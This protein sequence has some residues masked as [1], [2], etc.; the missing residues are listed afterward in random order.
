MDGGS[1][2]DGDCCGDENGLFELACAAAF[3]VDGLPSGVV[4][5][6]CPAIV[7]PG[8]DGSARW[9]A[10]G[11]ASAAGGCG[12][13]STPTCIPAVAAGGFCGVTGVLII[14]ARSRSLVACDASCTDVSSSEAAAI[15]CCDRST[16]GVVIRMPERHRQT[17][18]SGQHARSM[19]AQMSERTAGQRYTD[20][21]LDCDRRAQPACERRQ[22]RRRHSGGERAGQGKR[23][24]S[25]HSDHTPRR[26]A[27]PALVQPTSSA[28]MHSGHDDKTGSI[29]RPTAHQCAFNIT[30]A[31]SCYVR[32]C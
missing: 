27:R 21:P 15:R 16:S 23:R 8:V 12:G 22:Q 28:E 6:V 10:G 18:R 9:C 31:I 32:F 14:G 25:E 3:A 29:H 5:A 30:V 17:A 20:P 26:V 13:R 2:E 1:C 24:R 19:Q 11:M 4:I 7:S